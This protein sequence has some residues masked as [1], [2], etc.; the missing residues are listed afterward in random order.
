MVIASHRLSVVADSDLILVLDH[1]IVRERGNHRSLLA[2]GSLYA[3]ALRR[4][5]EA[6]ALESRPETNS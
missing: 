2:S 4:Q 3:A 5:N 1:G 6:N